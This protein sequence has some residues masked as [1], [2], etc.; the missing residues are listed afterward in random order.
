VKRILVIG[1]YGGFGARL[2]RRLS[3]AGHHVLVAGRSIDKARAFSAT[4]INAEPVVAD[5]RGDLDAVFR[6]CRPDLVIDAAGPFQ[7][8]AGSDPEYH[9][10]LACIKAAIPYLDLADSRVFVS[11]IASLNVQAIKAGIAILSGASS[12]PALS[13]A[14]VRHLTG[15]MDRVSS[16][17][18]AISASSR[19]TA[20]ASVA[21][22]ILSYAG[23]SVRLWRGGRWTQAWGWQKLRWL[24]LPL[25]AGGESR[26]RLVALADVPDHDILPATLPGR[27]A[28]TFRAGPEF[29]HQTLALWA[30][31]WLVRWGG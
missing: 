12:V 9:V 4:L 5:R 29:A 20:G 2:A 17:D 25:G 6:D 1:G 28:T 31:S 8:D 23:K 16:V 21:S 22:A 7:P 19:A 18:I 3:D 26:S 30:L 11:N 15:A 24:E 13:G 10:P 14:V 27:P